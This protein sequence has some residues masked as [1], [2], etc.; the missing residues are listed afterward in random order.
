MMEK[1]EEKG[2]ESSKRQQ[3]IH[4]KYIFCMLMCCLIVFKVTAINVFAADTYAVSVNGVAVD[5]TNAADV[6]GDGTVSYDSATNTLSLTDAALQSIT[7]NTGAAFTI[8]VSG[9]NSVT[10]ISGSSASKLIHSNSALIINGSGILELSGIDENDYIQCVSADGKVTVD[11]VQLK[12]VN[13][14][15]AGIVS[16]GDIDVLNHAKVTGNTGNLFRATNG[17]LTIVDSTVKAPDG[18]GEITGWNAVWVKDLELTGSVLEI[19]APSQAVCAE[20]NMVINQSDITVNSQ[21]INGQPGLWADGTM[22]ITDSTVKAESFNYWAVYVGGDLTI[23]GGSIEAITSHAT[24]S[25]MYS[26]GNINITG[27]VTVSTTT[28]GGVA[29]KAKKDIVIKT[30]SLESKHY[31][32]FAGDTISNIGQVGTGSFAANTDVTT[33]IGANACFQIEERAHSYSQETVKK[34]ALISAADCTNAAVYLKSCSCGQV[35]TN[36]ADVFTSGTPAGHKTVCHEAVEANCIATGN[37]EYWEC[38]SCNK[39]FNNEAAT[40]EIQLENTVVDKA[41][42]K[43]VSDGSGWYSDKDTHWNTCVCG[44]IFENTAHMFTW[45]IDREPTEHA[46]GLKHEQCTVCGY[47]KAGVEI[48]AT[49]TTTKPEEPTEP[50]KPEEPTTPEEPTKPTNPEEPTK[51]TEPTNP[52]EPTKPGES[53]APTIPGGTDIPDEE[54][55][56]SHEETPDDTVSPRTGD[57]SKPMFWIIISVIAG[58]GIASMLNLETRRK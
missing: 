32:A 5:S 29:L 2:K 3:N 13:S 33:D 56:E 57:T 22:T 53:E 8:H 48:P 27:P 15:D 1:V 47:A 9:Q 19:D 46:A 49:G 26:G 41:P 17:K 12:M 24:A 45:V 51:P 55:G 43:H 11:G 50:T 40:T 21:S 38:K 39:Y 36:N 30:G 23:S 44:V 4:S 35:S 28:L 34:E 42:D 58:I 54:G 37:V 6:L 14:Y 52:E 16:S 31:E 18:N 7:N 20:G 10:K 25:A